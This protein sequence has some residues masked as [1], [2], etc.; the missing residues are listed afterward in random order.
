M[1]PATDRRW[2]IAAA[3]ALMQLALGAIY[4]WSVFRDPLV[5]AFGWTIPEVTLAYTLNLFALGVSAFLGGLWVRRAGPRTVG[6]A[7]G[8]LYGLG[9]FLC[10]FAA[11][12]LWVLY[13][14][15]GV[16]G[17]LGRGLG[18]I[19]PVATVVKWFPDRRGLVAGLALAGN[20]LGALLV[21]PVATALIG[22]L[23]VIPTFAA[24]GVAFFVLVGGAA[25]A[26]R[27]P[28]E[29]FRPAG[30]EPSPALLAQRAPREYTVR[31]ALGTWQWYALWALLFLN[32]SAGL[33]LFSQAAPMAHE[34]TGVGAFVA[35]GMV[36]AMSV[37]NAAG[38]LSWAWASDRI[39][40]RWA[41]LA[42]L[43]VQAAVFPVLP[44]A[45][46][47][48]VFTL[49]ACLVFLCFGGGLATM[50]AFAADYFGPKHVGAIAG[51]LMTAQGFGAILGPLLL[52]QAREATGA[53]D[54]AL[55]VLATIMLA[56]AVLPCV[57]RPP[58]PAPRAE[59]AVG[60]RAPTTA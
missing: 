11:D 27:D 46:D 39:G 28:P 8:I 13:L 21:A 55:S 4:A 5:R 54:A 56:S 29:G 45:D 53:Y 49:L 15:F 42:M 35:A 38:R 48:L 18:W 14:G 31:E 24:L 3:A 2:L 17:G 6:I 41:F 26:M 58:S 40:R 47:A 57:I 33:G 36:G 1:E 12:R 60:E 20:G 25:L 37:A 19:V 7:A 30:W 43:L 44:R 51:L 9:V 16:L 32:G 34:I 50:P 22:E 59:P 23:G 52:A 10:S